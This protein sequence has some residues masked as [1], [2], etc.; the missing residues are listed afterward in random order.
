MVKPAAPTIGLHQT[1][2][3]FIGELINTIKEFLTVFQVTDNDHDFEQP[4]AWE[5]RDLGNRPGI[6]LDEALHLT[7]GD[8]CQDIVERI[9]TA[10][11]IEKTFKFPM[12]RVHH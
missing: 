7:F 12:V 3:I 8:R 1:N 4:S 10:H 11:P 2:V 9:E 6:T 5:N